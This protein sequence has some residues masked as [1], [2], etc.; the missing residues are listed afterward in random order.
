MTTASLVIT[1]HNH[2]ESVQ[3]KLKFSA[4]HGRDVII[5][6]ALGTD[7]SLNEHL[8]WLWGLVKHER[9]VL[10]K[11]AAEGARIVCS[12]RVPKGEIRLLPNAA[13]MLH[14]LGA[15]LILDTK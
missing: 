13:E 10:K 12:C 4:L 14:L 6:S 8:V 11:V 7:A 2:P 15:E 5:R 9:R 1:G 3:S